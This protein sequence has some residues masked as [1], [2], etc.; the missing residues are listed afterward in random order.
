MTADAPFSARPFHA[1]IAGPPIQDGCLP[2][3]EFR[4]F[5]ST[6]SSEFAAARDALA[7]DLLALRLKVTWQE[8]FRQEVTSDTLLR[9]I[10]DYVRDCQAVVCAVGRRSGA[11]PPP[12]AAAAFSHML[13]D[14]IAVASYTQWEL[15]FARH[16]KKRLS[17]YR[18]TGDY[19]PDQTTGP[20]VP[21]LQDAFLNHIDNEGL[22]WTGFG[23]TDRLCR[24]VLKEDWPNVPSDKPIILPYPSLGTLFKGRDAF[25]KR[26]RD[27]LTRPDGGKAAI[28]GRAVHGL[29]GVGKTRAA[30][31]YAWA[32]RDDYCALA[33]P[34][35]ETPDRLQTSLAALT[36][37]LRLA[38]REATD[39]AVQ[40]EAAV[41]W[42][43]AN[44]GWFLILDNLDTQPALDAAYQLLG[45]LSGGHVVLTSRL[46]QFPRGV[47]RLDLG[48]LTL[49]D[50]ASF[51]LEATAPGRLKAPDDDA[52]ARTLAHDLGQLALALEMAAATIDTKRL[53]FAAY[54]KL[55]QGNRTR[56]IGWAT[57]AITGYHHAVAETWQTSVDQLTPGGRALLERLAFLAPEP[58]PTFL[59]E[60][61]PVPG[62]EGED[63]EAAL[64]DLAAYSLATRDAATGTFLVHRLVQDVTRRGLA[65]AGR[66]KDR[67]T[68]ALGWVNAAFEGDPQDVGS[69]PRL[70][71]LAPHAEAVAGFADA[72]GIADP[73]ALLLNQLGMLFQVKALH[74]RGEPPMRRALAIAEASYGAAHPSV[75]TGL[76]NLAQLLQATNRLAEAEPLMRRALAIDE[77]S[78]GATHPNVARGLNNLAQVL[79][80]TNRLAEAEPLMRRMVLIFLLF[81]RDTGHPHPHRDAAL[82]NY[83][84]LLAAMGKTR[85]ATDMSIQ[86]LQRE[87]SLAPA[88]APGTGPA[89]R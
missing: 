30:V 12:T 10:H 86:S 19:S 67:L 39:Q 46:A 1:K 56:V 4:V 83:A 57:Q 89:A 81:Q 25:L 47:E 82:R 72:V 76:N 27:S 31:E 7:K 45:R 28:A 51:L 42:L 64:D 32:H 48:V 79:Q 20:D 37:P 5:L 71:P 50:A 17:V 61:V 80:A 59:L 23:S 55:W 87:A 36:G 77:A 9:L 49:D 41:A 69:W 14:G 18:A 73:T 78:Y 11:C 66:E 26:L 88:P 54:R 62:V 38:E 74:A 29:G 15:F 44:P 65:A 58:V 43:N 85:A 60:D 8:M 16:Y 75:A 35:A 3:S 33:L 2:V 24:E 52:Q 68:Q 34:D 22:H 40:A 6:V 21:G 13:P 53:N 63:A 70:D 84:I